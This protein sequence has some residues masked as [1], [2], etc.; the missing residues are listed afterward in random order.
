M[1]CILFDLLIAFVSFDMLINE[2]QQ[3]EV[4]GNVLYTYCAVLL[5]ILS[6]ILLLALF[7]TIIISKSKNK[8]KSNY[9]SNIKSNSN[10]Y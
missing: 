8:S 2:F 4:L 9:K 1:V 10:K 3:I 6:I 5:I 7:A